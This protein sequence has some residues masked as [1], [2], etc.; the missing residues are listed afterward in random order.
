MEMWRGAPFSDELPGFRC[1]GPKE[2]PIG[3]QRAIGVSQSMA[4]LA[5]DHLG[6]SKSSN[7]KLGHLGLDIFNDHHCCWV[8]GRLLA[9]GAASGRIMG[10]DQYLEDAKQPSCMIIAHINL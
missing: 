2:L 8:T 4:I 7:S 1:G 6:H 10:G 9:S 5:Q 3:V